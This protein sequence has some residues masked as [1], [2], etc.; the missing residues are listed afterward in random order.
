MFTPAPRKTLGVP[1]PP[2]SLTGLELPNA[3]IRAH[4]PG[5]GHSG[6]LCYAKALCSRPVCPT[7]QRKSHCHGFELAIRKRRFGTS[8]TDRAARHS[9]HGLR[10]RSK[11]LLLSK[12]TVLA[13]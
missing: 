13:L 4:R 7:H 1:F 11:C 3:G 8:T 6:G 2:F 10:V 9:R 5:N 12:A